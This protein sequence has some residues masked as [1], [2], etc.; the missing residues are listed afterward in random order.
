MSVL[1][2]RTSYDAFGATGARAPK[3]QKLDH[4]WD[5]PVPTPEFKGQRTSEIIPLHALVLTHEFF[6]RLPKLPPKGRSRF[7]TEFHKHLDLNATGHAAEQ[8]ERGAGA[9]GTPAPRT[10]SRLRPPATVLP[11]RWYLVHCTGDPAA[12]PLYFLPELRLGSHAFYRVLRETP[13]GALRGPAPALD[14][15]HVVV[16]PG[17]GPEIHEDDVERED[18][19]GR[20]CRCAELGPRGGRGFLPGLTTPHALHCPAGERWWEGRFE[21]GPFMKALWKVHAYHALRLPKT[22][23]ERRE[24]N[25]PSRTGGGLDSRLKAAVRDPKRRTSWEEPVRMAAFGSI[26]ALE[27]ARI[28]RVVRR[29]ALDCSQT[30]QRLVR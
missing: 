17:N 3:R 2:K 7:A 21:P 1:L 10:L 4:Y 13:T 16:C 25:L 8:P 18:E 6:R 29:R 12:P 22:R 5:A 20:A 14:S 19:E 24:K 9:Q 11:K 30:T 26:E 27:E 23:K 15:M 28:W